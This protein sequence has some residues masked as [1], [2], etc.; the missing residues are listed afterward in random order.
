MSEGGEGSRGDREL[1]RQR[2]LVDQMASMHSML[3]DRY[4]RQA[5]LFTCTLLVLSVVAVAFAFA[6]GGEQVSLVGWEAER[7]TWLGWFAVVV[8]SLAV[9]ELVLDRRGAAGRHDDAV[10]QLASL[11]LAYRTMSGS[12]DVARTKA[13]AHRY[14]AVMGSL[15]PIPERMFNRLKARHLAKL[16]VSKYL[17][18]NPGCPRVI[19]RWRVMRQS[20]Q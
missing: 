4:Q 12:E 16:E 3:R 15:P 19:A 2:R 14:E 9:I 17:S 20:T 8:F 7:S 1:D 18:A 5:T 13:L 11:K 10:R 6:A